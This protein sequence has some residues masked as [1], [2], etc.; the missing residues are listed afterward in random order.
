MKDITRVRGRQG[1]QK[2]FTIVELLISLAVFSF[3][4]VTIII[5]F[6]QIFASYN[7]AIY[8]KTVNDNARNLMSDITAVLRTSSQG[9][10]IVTS[11][12]GNGRLCIGGTSYVWN[13]VGGGTANTV[14]GSGKVNVVKITGDDGQACSTAGNNIT[15]GGTVTSMFN[16]QVGIQS[17]TVTAV[18]GLPNLYQVTLTTTTNNS[19]FLNASG[20]CKYVGTQAGSQFCSQV[21]LSQVTGLLNE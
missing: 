11:D 20:K 21:T 4:M 14:N 2:G 8:R 5:A 17:L 15:T 9:S 7:T 6:T 13:A 1:E 12:T 18:T 16:N 3:V 10:S 19:V